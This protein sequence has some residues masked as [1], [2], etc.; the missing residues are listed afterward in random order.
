MYISNFV[1]L[2]MASISSGVPVVH[3]MIVRVIEMHVRDQVLGHN[4]AQ[5][6]HVETRL[7]YRP[8]VELH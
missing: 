8:I 2:V 1:P 7:V 3:R 5:S 4:L 6:L